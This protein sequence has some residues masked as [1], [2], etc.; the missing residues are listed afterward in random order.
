[1][2]KIWFKLKKNYFRCINFLFSSLLVIISLFFVINNDVTNKNTNFKSSYTTSKNGKVNVA[3]TTGSRLSNEEYKSLKDGVT[4]I[5]AKYFCSYYDGKSLATDN[6]FD[7]EVQPIKYKDPW[8]GKEYYSLA[9][10]NTDWGLDI[11]NKGTYYS[12]KDYGFED[13]STS[14]WNMDQGEEN[15]FNKAI[16]LNFT[17]P[18]ELLI[19]YHEQWAEGHVFYGG[20]EYVVTAIDD[21]ACKEYA[22]SHIHCNVFF[23][24]TVTYI[25]E[26]AFKETNNSTV[27]GSANLGFHERYGKNDE[28]VVI[29]EGLMFIKK[30]AFYKAGLFGRN[31]DAAHPNL[32]NLHFP[33]TLLRIEEEA[34]NSTSNDSSATYDRDK[35]F[36]AFIDFK[37]ANSLNFIG[38]KAFYSVSKLINI[39]GFGNTSL[40][41][42]EDYAFSSTNV[43]TASSIKFPSTLMRIGKNALSGYYDG[44][45][46][47]IYF[48]DLDFSDFTELNWITISAT[49]PIF[50]FMPEVSSTDNVYLHLPRFTSYSQCKMF[51]ISYWDTLNKHSFNIIFNNTWQEWLDFGS[52]VGFSFIDFPVSTTPNIRCFFN[53]GEQDWSSYDKEQVTKIV[54]ENTL[55]V[56]FDIKCFDTRPLRSTEFDIN[57]DKSDNIDIFVGQEETYK[58]VIPDTYHY[59]SDLSYYGVSWTKEHIVI[60]YTENGLSNIDPYAYFEIKPN[61]SIKT[62]SKIIKG[63]F[64]F[65]A[66]KLNA[67]PTELVY[68]WM[69]NVPVS[70]SIRFQINVNSKINLNFDTLTLY[71]NE[72]EDAY[73]LPEL[74][75][76]ASITYEL[77]TSEWVRIPENA[78]DLIKVVSPKLSFNE[79]NQIQTFKSPSTDETRGYILL[80]YLSHNRDIFTTGSITVFNRE[81]PSIEISKTDFYLSINYPY[82][83]CSA[84]GIGVTEKEHELFVVEWNIFSTDKQSSVSHK[85]QFS[86]QKSSLDQT[87]F[88]TCIDTNWLKTVNLL[89]IHANVEGAKGIESWANLHVGDYPHLFEGS[90]VITAAH[91]SY[92]YSR[93]WYVGGSNDSRVPFSDY[94]I[95]VKSSSDIPAYSILF[96]DKANT[97]DI[98]FENSIPVGIYNVWL[99]IKVKSSGME[100][101]SSVITLTV[102]DA[103]F[104]LKGGSTS[105]DVFSNQH[106]VDQNSWEVYNSNS[107]YAGKV[108]YS[109][110]KILYDDSA[111]VSSIDQF[112]RLSIN[113]I[114]KTKDSFYIIRIRCKVTLSDLVSFTVYSPNIKI[115]ILDTNDNIKIVSSTSTSI[116]SLYGVK[117]K[118]KNFG[119]KVSPSISSKYSV[120][121]VSYSLSTDRKNSIF[122]DEN[123]AV[124]WSDDL[125]DGSYNFV[126]IAAVTLE[127]LSDS[128]NELLLNVYSNVYTIY[129]NHIELIDHNFDIFLFSSGKISSPLAFKKINNENVLFLDCKFSDSRFIINKVDKCIYAT[130]NITSPIDNIN[131]KLTISYGSSQLDRITYVYNSYIHIGIGK[132]IELIKA[133]FL[134]FIIPLVSLMWVISIIRISAN[135]KRGNKKIKKAKGSKYDEIL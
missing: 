43:M 28:G 110:E 85:F 24:C 7:V 119:L 135:R 62:T 2:Q 3:D 123:N 88:I 70:Y 134:Y 77:Y 37:D 53:H 55:K 22:Y 31:I 44:K 80:A 41:D 26:E 67:N 38:T 129:I 132:T 94:S 35:I 90:N 30:K 60:Q 45:L 99:E 47:Y 20:V 48:N 72:T 124:N 40:T 109:I 107:V 121:S 104:S 128:H 98:R 130:S 78:D 103:D 76:T 97:F 57:V 50:N 23:P 16:A 108:D 4:S 12:D 102:T 6:N 64:S 126:V 79:K 81:K 133:F 13:V 127:E 54:K 96:N 51:N 89:F 1:M 27:D 68:S 87:I 61:E 111:L 91:L 39:F 84:K 105:L 122:L 120:K 92:G 9:I 125:L 131:I 52:S 32:F 14:G 29:H 34:F 63:K 5:P 101:D 116:E 66:N 49:Q 117:G 86:R 18:K 82:F 36:I 46:G 65:S 56:N 73:V 114:N 74:R 11:G 75:S 58:L 42:I 19:P 8:T 115:N 33:S 25:G 118:T 93:G 69:N 17:T 100:I 71:S 83:S 15:D 113:S 21:N 10:T 95:S 112:G 106:L 59:H